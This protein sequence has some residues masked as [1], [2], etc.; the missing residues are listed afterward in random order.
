LVVVAVNAA[1]GLLSGVV[2]TYSDNIIK[3]F[4]GSV[5]LVLSTVVSH[6][7]LGFQPGAMF[8]AGTAA[9]GL[10]SFLYANP[11]ALPLPSWLSAAPVVAQ[12]VPDASRHKHYGRVYKSRKPKVKGKD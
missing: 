9:V 3:G 4:A 2:L 11:A 12:S 10:S 8:V 6:I 7:F 5:A 1:G